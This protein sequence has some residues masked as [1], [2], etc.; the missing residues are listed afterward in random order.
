MTEF[1]RNRRPAACL[2]ALT[3][4]ALVAALAGRSA[5]GAPEPDSPLRVAVVD[6]SRVLK[7][8]AAWRDAAEERSRMIERMQRTLGQR[9]REAQVLRNELENLPPGT[10]QRQAKALELQRALVQLQ[11][12]QMEFEAGIAEHHNAAVRDLLGRLARAAQEHARENGI[13]LVLKRQGMEPD[14]ASPQ[15]GLEMATADVLYAAERL[16]VTDAV[17]ARL[18]AEHEGP[19]EVR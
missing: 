19:I 7:E 1:I 6:M 10:D 3:A 18:N 14:A 5:A 15:Q 11:Q 4:L 2:C 16:D 8:A 13:D 12:E 17:V 9:R